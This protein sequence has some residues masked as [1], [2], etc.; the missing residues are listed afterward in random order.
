MIIKTGLRKNDVIV[1]GIRYTDW[2]YHFHHTVENDKT[3]Q[4][5]RKPSP[6]KYPLL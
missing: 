2:F 3:N 1:S 6:G 4:P 5:P